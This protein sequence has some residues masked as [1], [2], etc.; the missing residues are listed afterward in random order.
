MARG[1]RNAVKILEEGSLSE[2]VR[3]RYA[4]WDTEL[5]KQIEEGKGDFEYL[6]KKAKEIGEPKVPSAK[7]VQVSY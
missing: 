2:L 3:K 4:S 1:L 5:G 7:Q 6:E